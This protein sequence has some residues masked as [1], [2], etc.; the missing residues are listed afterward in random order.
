M[1]TFHELDC[2]AD[3]CRVPIGVFYREEGRPTYEDGLK[4]TQTPGW[5]HALE[6]RD[7][8]GIMAKL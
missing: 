8:S 7:V 3:D 6:P 4:A 2:M 1:S 5:Q